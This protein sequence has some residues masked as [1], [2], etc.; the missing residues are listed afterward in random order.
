MP[1]Q[2]KVALI[3]LGCPKN[4]V[5][6]EKVLGQIVESGALVC[7]DVADA[8]LI[9]INTCTF[10]EDATAES[11]DV[12]CEAI[13]RKQAG[14]CR[15]V[16]VFGCLA[17]LHGKA[18]A[19]EMPE[20]DAWVG[21]DEEAKIAEI[22]RSLAEG[23]S[24][25]CAPLHV[26]RARGPLAAHDSR[27][28]ITPQHYAYLKIS[29]GCDNVCAFCIIPKIRGRHRSKLREAVLSEAH[30]LV[31]DGARELVIVAQDTTDYGRDLYG[32]RELA[33]LLHDLGGIDGLKWVRLL[34]AFPA[35]FSDEMIEELATSP[36][37]VNYLDL[38]IQHINDRLLKLMGREAGREETESLI[39]RLRDRV[40]GLVLRTSVIV[41]YPGET[42]EELEEL[43][44]FLQE[45]RFDRLGAFRYSHEQGTVAYGRP[46]QVPKEVRSERLDR[47]MAVQQSIAFENARKMVGG[48][49][50]VVI[51]S[52]SADT[53]DVWE[54][55]SYGE[56]PEIDGVI[57]VQGSGLEVGCFYECEVSAADG[58]DLVAV[59][60]DRRYAAPGGRP[61]CHQAPAESDE[62]PPRRRL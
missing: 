13:E 3:S 56:A 54:G 42:E 9:V 23:G 35:H 39:A 61:T 46:D 49:L 60:A 43:L 53:P 22:C 15:A 36:K 47:V 18:L 24:G 5:D 51:D 48:K 12:I 7:E 34:Y 55:R 17:Q 1:E 33:G 25:H 58:Y 38:P 59:P 21:V 52:E 11:L 45:A 6:S 8:D 57:R 50:E 19:A 41:G 4:V 16:V 10:I 30:E 29:E 44:Q 31:E 37:I 26:E 20:V 2:A 32:K 27:L 14:E 28:R 62:L 40:P